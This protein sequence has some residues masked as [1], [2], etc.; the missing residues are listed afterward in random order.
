MSETDKWLSIVAILC[1]YLWLSI[2]RR[3]RAAQAKRRQAWEQEWRNEPNS[4]L[5]VLPRIER[6]RA[7]TYSGENFHPQFTPAH[8]W[9]LAAARQVVAG[10]GYFC[11]ARGG[12]SES[13]SQETQHHG[14]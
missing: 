5:T 7:N 9:L 13:R 3:R 6:L 14:T 4:S 12:T 8:R 11:T 1:V 2:R 10:L